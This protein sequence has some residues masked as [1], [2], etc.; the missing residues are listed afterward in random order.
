MYFFQQRVARQDRRR[1]LDQPHPRVGQISHSRLMLVQKR[2]PNGTVLMGQLVSQSGS[3]NPS[4]TIASKYHHEII[5]RSAMSIHTNVN[6]DA[7]WLITFF[8]VQFSDVQMVLWV[9]DASLKTWMVPTCVSI[10]YYVHF[11]NR[12]KCLRSHSPICEGER[13]WKWN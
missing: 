10:T 1:S 6:L 4:S 8:L 9:R 13:E 2:M 5:G 3:G 11:A 12:E 7:I